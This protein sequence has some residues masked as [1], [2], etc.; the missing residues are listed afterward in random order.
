MKPS[1]DFDPKVTAKKLMR[2]ARS[3][4]LA[5]LM[6]GS[7]DPY[8][9]LVNIAT[10]A[11]GAPL[12][13]ISRLAVH[14][15][16][17]L[18]D[19]RASLMLD[20]RKEG[21]PLQG[22]RVMLMGTVQ[23]TENPDARRR[24]LAYQPEAEMFAD[25]ADFAFY[26]LKLKGAH[27]VAGFGRIVDLAPADLL[28]DVS[29]AKAMLEAEPSAIEHMNADHADTCRLYATKLLGAPDGAWRCVGCDPEGLDLQW[30]R[31]GL[32]LP[33]PKR[34]T[35]PGALRVVLKQLAEQARAA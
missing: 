22:A 28:T 26:E 7:G 19:P 6:A 2:E 20:E 5:T 32:R 27:L 11:D 1:A 25:F 16:N 12:L 24:Y 31:I 17:A 3:G 23:K 35:E 33:F 30:E 21:D 29:D 8:C 4:A 18:A 14:T 9:S 34:V 13:L 10:M 15:R